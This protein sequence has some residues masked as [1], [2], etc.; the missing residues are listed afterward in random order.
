MLPPARLWGDT[1]LHHAAN[2]NAHHIFEELYD[3]DRSALNRRS[4]L[5]RTPLMRAA[6]ASS[7][8]FAKRLIG[9]DADISLTDNTGE[10]AHTS[11]Y[12]SETCP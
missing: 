4:E 1:E 10:A 6:V 3:M 7:V 2:L 5:G 9:V 12:G 8:P 11:R